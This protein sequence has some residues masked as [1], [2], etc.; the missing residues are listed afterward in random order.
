MLSDL[1]M[2]SSWKTSALESTKIQ[3][4]ETCLIAFLGG[5]PS[6]LVNYNFHFSLHHNVP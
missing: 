2:E 1:P 4:S 5:F 3:T 6:F